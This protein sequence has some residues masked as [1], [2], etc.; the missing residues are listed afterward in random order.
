VST[1]AGKEKTE[2][3]NRSLVK[4]VAAFVDHNAVVILICVLTWIAH[5]ALFGRFGLYEDDYSHIAPFLRWDVGALAERFGVFHTW[6]Q[7]RPLQYIFPP[8]LTMVFYPIGGLRL[9]YFAAYVITSVTGILFYKLALKVTGSRLF[10]VIASLAFVFFPA[11]TTH[12]FLMHAFALRI[13]LALVI[14]ACL[15]YLSERYVLACILAFA[16]LIT[17]ESFFLVFLAFP[18]LKNEWDRKEGILELL[19]HGAISTGLIGFTVAMR[20][21]NRESRVTD[22]AGSSIIDTIK[23]VL[24]RFFWGPVTALRQLTFGPALTLPDWAIGSFIVLLITAVLVYVVLRIEKSKDAAGEQAQRGELGIY[25]L[26]ALARSGGID[27]D[28]LITLARLILSS[29]AVLVLAYLFSFTHDPLMKLGRLTSVHMAASVG[30][31]LFFTALAYTLFYLLRRPL[32]RQIAL[33][34]LALHFGIFGGYRFLIQEDFARAWVY[35]KWFW[36]NVVN[37]SGEMSDRTMIVVDAKDIP[38]TAY[39]QTYSFAASKMLS[40]LFE[41]PSEWERAPI[42]LPTAFSALVEQTDSGKQ[43]VYWPHTGTW[44]EVD[45]GNIIVLTLG[46]GGRLEVLNEP[47]ATI[48]DVTLALMYP[49]EPRPVDLPTTPLY[50][51]MINEEYLVIDAAVR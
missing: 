26:P 38:Q 35:Q 9:L 44:Y 25:R 17:Y 10:A 28:E 36:T 31:S 7:G 19:R 40:L 15:L 37:I 46:G 48:R 47:T 3:M 45:G 1:A 22:L 16:G 27:R 33:G 8:I 51:L 34:V 39:I 43:G 21:F 49:V 30:G 14:G 20:L 5:F 24:Y 13:A 4:N 6:K 12:T 42:A 18:I 41:M 32:Y 2:A 29:G 11:D 23:A 50:D